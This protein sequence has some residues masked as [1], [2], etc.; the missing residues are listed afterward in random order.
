MHATLRTAA[1]TFAGS[2]LVAR[3]AGLLPGVVFAIGVAAN[4]LFVAW[5]LRAPHRGHGDKTWKGLAARD[6]TELAWWSAGVARMTLGVGALGDAAAA[7]ALG[8][9]G[10]A[11]QS[12]EFCSRVV[13][14]L[15]RAMHISEGESIALSKGRG[16]VS[17]SGL[18]VA[19]P[20]PRLRGPSGPG[21]LVPACLDTDQRVETRTRQSGSHI[22]TGA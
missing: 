5:R 18:D 8:R 21:A 6:T 4:A 11:M 9:A 15:R 13:P 19:A 1:R 20:W 16:G 2:L 17:S 3:H 14:L 7:R 10:R 22:S 12:G